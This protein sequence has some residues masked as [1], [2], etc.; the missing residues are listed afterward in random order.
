MTKPASF[1]KILSNYSQFKQTEMI[2]DDQQLQ[3]ELL[4]EDMLL[5]IFGF[6]DEKNLKSATLVCRR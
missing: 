3:I 4:P 1:H 2:Q 6:M 5:V